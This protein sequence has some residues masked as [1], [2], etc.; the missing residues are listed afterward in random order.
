MLLAKNLPLLTQLRGKRNLLA[1]SAGSDSSALYHLLHQEGIT[2]D[3]ALVNYQTRPNSDAEEAFAH[4]LAQRDNRRCFTR[5]IRLQSGNFEATARHARYAFF[6][7]LIRQHGYERLITAHHLNDRTEWLLMRLAKGAGIAELTGMQPVTF[8]EGYRIVR[9]LIHTPKSDILAY[10]KH[11]NITYFTDESNADMRFERNRLRIFVNDFV[12]THAK[13]IARTFDYLQEDTALLLSLFETTVAIKRLR[14]LS[15]SHPNAA[16]K[17][18]DVTLKELGY[19]LSGK[20]RRR[21]NRE[22]RLVIGRTWAVARVN[23]RLYIAPYAQNVVMPKPFKERCRKHNIPPNIRPYLYK[24][25]IAP[26][27][28]AV[29]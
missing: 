18:V 22:E 17:A 20:E 8:K 12:N 14:V 6:E 1:F 15:L 11:H 16:A 26:E 28:I 24:E 7:T 27:D 21:I 13:G 10:L 9:P 19:L 25:A 4:T 2:F 5:R 3:I 23:L 29:S